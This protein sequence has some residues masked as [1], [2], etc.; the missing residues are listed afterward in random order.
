MNI[1]RQSVYVLKALL[2]EFFRM[3]SF[4]KELR[5]KQVEDN[6]CNQDLLHEIPF[7]EA[8]DTQNGIVS[9]ME[10]V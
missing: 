8:Q 6:Y 3:C 2:K 9:L 4:S 1:T 5:Y 10:S 7:K